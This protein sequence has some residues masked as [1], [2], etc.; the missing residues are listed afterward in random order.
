M[1]S[2]RSVTFGSL[3]KQ[4]RMA[5]GLTQEE[6]AARAGISAQAIGSLER[7]ARRAEIQFSSLWERWRCL[8][9]SASSSKPLP[10]AE[11]VHRVPPSRRR[12]W[13]L[14]SSA[15]APRWLPSPAI[16]PASAPLCLSS[17]ASQASASRACW[18]R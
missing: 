4:Y 18:Q 8:N 9:R 15:E 12:C 11:R 2:V 16:W 7:G 14:L 17:Q 3:L 10:A 5:A 6:L 1:V 13:P